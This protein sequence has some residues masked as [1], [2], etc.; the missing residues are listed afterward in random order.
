MCLSRGSVYPLYPLSGGFFVHDYSSDMCTCTVY[1]RYIQAIKLKRLIII[2]TF[3]KLGGGGYHGF[4]KTQHEGQF[5][6]RSSNVIKYETSARE[7]KCVQTKG[8]ILVCTR[9]SSELE[10][11][12]AVKVKN[13]CSKISYHLYS[14]NGTSNCIHWGIL[15][16]KNHNTSRALTCQKPNKN[17]LHIIL[18]N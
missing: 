7:K 17:K 4:S 8:S 3:I 11:S 13:K 1:I 14:K 16:R 2:I 10:S 18:P 15:V 5:A 12:H 6:G 9:S